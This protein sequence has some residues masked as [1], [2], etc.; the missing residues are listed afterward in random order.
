MR[1]SI[2]VAMSE[3]RV[4]GR[5][6][7]LPWR[8]SA[9]LRR[10]KRLT[11]GHH[12]VMGRKTFESIGR[13]LPGRTSI[14]LTRDSAFAFPGAVIARSLEQAVKRAGDDQEIFLIGGGQVYR[15]T[16]EKADRL[17]LTMVHAEVDGDTYFPEI[18]LTQWQLV[19]RERHSADDKNE[20]DY[21]F[22]V[23]DRVRDR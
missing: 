9:D 23:Y 1:T 5:Q 6:G 20:H 4:I 19:D 16:L 7:G 17:Y 2:I 3:N 22:I 10:F 21:S 12:I 11:M 18:H 8:L 15:E 13:L 14:V